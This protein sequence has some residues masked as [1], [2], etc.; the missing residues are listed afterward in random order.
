[1]NRPTRAVLTG[2]VIAAVATTAPVAAAAAAPQRLAQRPFQGPGA[3]HLRT[4]MI[5]RLP[6]RLQVLPAEQTNRADAVVEGQ[7]WTGKT[8]KVRLTVRSQK[9]GAAAGTLVWSGTV[10]RTLIEQVLREAPPKLEARVGA[11]LR[12]QRLTANARVRSARRQVLSAATARPATVSEDDRSDASA[13][14]DAASEPDASVAHAAGEPR[15]KTTPRLAAGGPLLEVSVGA[16]TIG[17]TLTF[18]DNLAAAPGY[19]LP[20]A[21]TL[22]GELVVFPGARQGG[23]LGMVGLAGAWESTI[24]ASTADRDG[25]PSHPTRHQ[26]YSLG[27]RGRLPFERATLVAGL[28]LGQQRFEVDLPGATLS[29]AVRYRFLRPSLGG[30]LAIDDFALTLSAAYLQVLSADLGGAV[31]PRAEVRGFELGARLGYDIADELAVELRLDF[32]RFAHAMNA[33]PG[34]SM[35][36]GGAVDDYLA[37][38][39]RLSYRVW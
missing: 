35:L 32:R 25:Q 27:A 1:M 8:W 6:R 2:L 33:R 24:A 9:T 22:G 10:P 29:P 31:F 7:I 16:G 14:T 37:A 39:L 15:G 28:D 4:A 20:A 13:D 18:A 19:S 30:R 36:V 12:Q 23:W 11:M 17:R 38:A 5:A 21:S 34:D 3:D 26:A